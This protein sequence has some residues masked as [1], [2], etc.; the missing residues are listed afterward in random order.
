MDSK[1]TTRK[2]KVASKTRSKEEKETKKLFES[3]AKKLIKD[4][5]LQFQVQ[6]QSLISANMD[7]V[8]HDMISIESSLSSRI[9]TLESK[10]SNL[11][12]RCEE[13]TMSTKRAMDLIQE[14]QS[15][16]SDIMKANLELERSKRTAHL[17]K[18]HDKISLI[19]S[20]AQDNM[21]SLRKDQETVSSNLHDAIRVQS[22]DMSLLQE[23]VDE[24]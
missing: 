4:Q 9:I 3:I 21:N 1:K 11:S 10:L 24:L 6:M 17:K 12:E 13:I 7:S 5:L 18:L 19:H 2:P 20:E 23:R 14:Q 15:S 16:S 22:K 8:R